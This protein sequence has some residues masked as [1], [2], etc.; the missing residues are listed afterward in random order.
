[1]AARTSPRLLCVSHPHLPIRLQFL[2]PKD[3]GTVGQRMLETDRRPHQYHIPTLGP[4][5][6]QAKVQSRNAR[7][8]KSMIRQATMAVRRQTRLKGKL[9]KFSWDPAH[10]RL[11]LDRDWLAPSTLTIPGNIRTVCCATSSKPRDKSNNTFFGHTKSHSTVRPA[12]KLSRGTGQMSGLTG[13]S[14]RGNASLEKRSP[15]NQLKVS[16][17]IG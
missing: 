14:S 4:S 1:M 15:W 2:P 3:K 7:H 11:H 12:A 17:P 8:K 13:T 6:A 10:F 9:S 16:V 5:Q